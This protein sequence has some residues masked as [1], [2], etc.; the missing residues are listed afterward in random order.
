MDPAV[1][2]VVSRRL[3]QQRKLVGLDDIARARPLRLDVGHRRGTWWHCGT[4][5]D[6]MENALDLPALAPGISSSASAASY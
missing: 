3:V 1:D 6:T 5:A 4:L 2:F